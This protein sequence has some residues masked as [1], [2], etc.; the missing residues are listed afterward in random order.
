[1]I[2]TRT[3]V[4]TQILYEEEKIQELW[5]RI[6]KKEERAIN[7]PAITGK[8]ETGDHVVLNTTAVELSLGTGGIHFVM[9]RMGHSPA[10]E[11]R[12]SPDRH[13]M[14]MRY[15][16]VQIAT[17]SCEEQGS[18]YHDIFLQKN[19][20]E[21]M[22]VLVGELHSMLPIA[23]SYIV[24]VNKDARIVYIMTDKGSL[25]LAMSKHIRTLN[26]LEW[27]IGTITTGHAFGG[28]LEALNIYTALLAA[29]HI[30]NADLAIV[31]MGPG[32]A[33]TGT[34]LGF[35]G[36]E[37]VEILHAAFSMKGTP[38]LIPRAGEGDLRYRHQGLSH[39]TQ[40]VLNHT[41]IPV[42]FPLLKELE[43]PFDQRFSPH[44][45]H[46][47]SKE[48]MMELPLFLERY[49]SSITTMGRG[50]RE[51]PLFFY[52]VAAAAHFAQRIIRN[53]N[54]LSDTT[55]LEQ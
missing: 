26:R 29:K 15:T 52:S 14:K 39:H 27:L 17:G 55:D 42:H 37:Q 7:Y 22:P 23:V 20:L 46:Y 19:S 30:L 31:T 54:D 51:D 50:W 25:P 2:Q 41:L 3:G 36:M 53:E 45:T 43:D 8:V 9:H 4:V 38:I 35:T 48:Q 12:L 32:I 6:E 10:S 47:I 49:P 21:G 13:I 34:P 40:A 11:G 5:V 16:P 33:G 1:M 18:P 28:D 44:L 24:E